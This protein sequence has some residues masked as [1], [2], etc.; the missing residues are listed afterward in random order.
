MR[1]ALPHSPD[2]PSSRVV[3]LAKYEIEQRAEADETCGDE[4]ATRLDDCPV[5]EDDRGTGAINEGVVLKEGDSSEDGSDETTAERQSG[6]RERLS[7]YSHAACSEGE[8]ESDLDSQT[9]LQLPHQR[10][11][12][13]QHKE[14]GDR[15][16]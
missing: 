2:R 5:E 6:N 1:E 15:V 10:K 4:V 12:K 13:Q 7:W 3:R 11:W 9:G 16:W 14:V 8:H